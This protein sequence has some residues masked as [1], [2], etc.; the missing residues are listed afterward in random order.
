MRRE[1]RL[2]HR[3]DFDAVYREG[4]SVGA[5]ALSLRTR[6]NGLTVSR[7]GFAVGKRVG[8]A[9]VRN[10]VKRRLRAVVQALTL[11]AGWDV[12]ITARARA[13]D[14][15]Y[16]ELAGVVSMLARRAWL[17]PGQPAERRQPA[18]AVSPGPERRPAGPPPSESPP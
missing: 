16:D 18:P 15:D 6:R 8:K 14:L 9:V 5:E 4:R 13:A 11:P 3:R 7:F 17:L 10:R 12:V 1:Q 2:R